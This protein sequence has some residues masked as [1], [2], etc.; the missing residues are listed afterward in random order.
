MPK[1]TQRERLA[2]LQARQC[3]LD[4]EIE[5]TRQALRD[6]YAALVRD[7]PVE[8]LS[9]AGFQRLLTEILRVGGDVALAAL[10]GLET[11][12]RIAPRTQRRTRPSRLQMPQS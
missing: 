1:M 4:E 9:E 10:K 7:L 3:K 6:R 11:G 5:A 12:D 8:Q 2:E